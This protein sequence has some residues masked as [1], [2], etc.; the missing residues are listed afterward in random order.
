[1]VVVAAGAGHV[2]R[3][4]AGITTIQPRV[5]SSLPRKILTTLFAVGRSPDSSRR[6]SVKGVIVCIVGRGGDALWSKPS[7]H[8]F[9]KWKKSITA[10]DYVRI[11]WTPTL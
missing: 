11:P 5:R 10:A 7:K 3:N 8:P 6:S 2:A 1:M 4:T 9:N